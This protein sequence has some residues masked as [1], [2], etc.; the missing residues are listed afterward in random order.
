MAKRPPAD[1]PKPTTDHGL[2]TREVV[3]LL[4]RIEEHDTYLEAA[5]ADAERAWRLNLAPA[6]LVDFQLIHRYIYL[7]ENHPDWLAELTF[8][9]E[10]PG[11]QF[12]IGPGTLIELANH[13]TLVQESLEN[14]VGIDHTVPSLNA[15]RTFLALIDKMIKEIITAHPNELYAIHRL[16]ELLRRSSFVH[17]SELEGPLLDPD[18]EAYRVASAA[19]KRYRPDRRKAAP[20]LAD[21]LNFAATVTLRRATIT[22]AFPVFPYL[23]T[24]T[25]SLLNEGQWSYDPGAS[26]GFSSPIS[27]SPRSAVASHVVMTSFDDLDRGV[28]HCEDMRVEASQVRRQ[29]KRLRR[30]SRPYAGLHG[31]DWESLI[32]HSLLDNESQATIKRVAAFFD[33]DV[34]YRVQHVVENLEMLIATFQADQNQFLESVAA[35]RRL[36]SLVIRVART[37]DDSRRKAAASVGEMWRLAVLAR[38]T[39]GKSYQGLEFLDRDTGQRLLIAHAERA[40]SVAVTYSWPTFLDLGLALAFFNFVSQAHNVSAGTIVYGTPNGVWEAPVVFPVTLEELEKSVGSDGPVH[41]VRVDTAAFTLYS[42]LVRKIGDEA[43][44]SFRSS[45]ADVTQL[46]SMY[47]A[48]ARNYVFPSWSRRILAISADTDRWA[49]SVEEFDGDR[50]EG[51]E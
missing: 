32:D 51:R 12:I 14:S 39:E 34:I 30:S 37:L 46:A 43:T 48:T 27:R 44:L 50:P 41:W 3:Q 7:N 42:E 45:K 13:L 40:G 21:A 29:V 15:L 49:E 9:F 26:W 35:S 38:T 33:D 17:Y 2:S 22:G 11:I 24:A 16:D 18:P 31:Q 47:E 8:L 19:M 23:L 5:S 6:Y 20:N 10:Q 1:S 28:Q 36:V 25:P 4:G